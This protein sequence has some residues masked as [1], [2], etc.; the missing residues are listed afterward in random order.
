MEGKTMERLITI[1]DEV[2]LDN[3][4]ERPS[5]YTYH[6]LRGQTFKRRNQNI[7]LKLQD[8][9][10]TFTAYGSKA[11]FGSAPHLIDSLIS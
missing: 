8:G 4:K 3:D 6:I 9:A 7:Y 5:H 1:G 10:S 11:H 2:Y